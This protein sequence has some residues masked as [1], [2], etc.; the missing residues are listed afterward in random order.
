MTTKILND[1]ALEE[2]YQALFQMYGSPGWKCLMEDA[3]RMRE[4]HDSVSGVET[5]R[6]L[7]FRKGEIT[8]MDW[9]LSHQATAEASYA[10]LMTDQEGG[11]EAA[12]TGGVAKVIE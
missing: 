10:A 1:T 12:P 9:A 4:I 11:D 5:E 2:Y 6:Q 3:A 8:Q 7:W